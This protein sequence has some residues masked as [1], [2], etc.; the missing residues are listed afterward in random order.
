MQWPINTL[1]QAGFDSRSLSQHLRAA[2]FCSI[3]LMPGSAPFSLFDDT[4][5]TTFLGVPIS[6]NMVAQAC[7][8]DMLHLNSNSRIEVS[9]PIDHGRFT[10]GLTPVDLWYTTQ[11]SGNVKIADHPSSGSAY[12]K[13]WQMRHA[14]FQQTSVACFSLYRLTFSL[15]KKTSLQRT[16]HDA[17]FLA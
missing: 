5:R 9:I 2:G 8:R 3:G 13:Q 6:L 11:T 1:A 7:E 12:A 10:A 16:H 4:S 14:A 15:T 17:F